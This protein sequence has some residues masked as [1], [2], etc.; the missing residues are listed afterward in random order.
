MNKI[1]KI[2]IKQIENIQKFPIKN[3]KY[4][5]KNYNS[6]NSNINTKKETSYNLSENG[7]NRNNINESINNY[8]IKINKYNEKLTDNTKKSS[9]SIINHKKN[10]SPISITHYT[11]YNK[12]QNYFPS[13]ENIY[14]SYKKCNHNNTNPSNLKSLN[15]NINLV[16]N[17]TLPKIDDVKSPYFAQKAK[18]ILK[19][20][21]GT[22]KKI[23]NLSI[24]SNNINNSTLKNKMINSTRCSNT[25]KISLFNKIKNT[26]YT[27]K[28]WLSI[29]NCSKLYLYDHP[30]ALSKFNI[31]NYHSNRDYNINK[32]SIYK[33]NKIFNNENNSF[34]NS[35]KKDKCHFQSCKFT[36]E[37]IR[38]IL[39]E[40]NEKINQQIK[41]KIKHVKELS[42]IINNNQRVKK[43]SPFKKNRKNIGAINTSYKFL[44]AH[45]RNITQNI[46]SCRKNNKLDRKVR[47]NED[48]KCSESK[49]K[50]KS[51]NKNKII[52]N[53]VKIFLKQKKDRKKNLTNTKLISINEHK[54]KSTSIT[55]KKIIRSYPRQS[56][57]PNYYSSLATPNY[58]SNGNTIKIDKRSHSH[59]LTNYYKVINK[60]GMKKNSISKK[61]LENSNNLKVKTLKQKKDKKEEKNKN[62]NINNNNKVIIQKLNIKT[63]DNQSKH[64]NLSYLDIL[65]F[66]KNDKPN[67]SIVS[68]L[69][70][71]EYYIN[72]MKQ[73]SSYIKDFYNNS[74]TYPKTEINFY[75][76]G[77]VLGKG[78]FG[79]VNLALHL[80]SGRLVAIKSFNKSKILS[81]RA[82]FK[83]KNEIEVLSKLRN[84]FC[85]QIYDFFETE[86]HILIVMEYVCGDLLSFIRK[87]GKISENSSKII[88]K[89]LIKG[90]QYIHNKKIVHRDIKL[91]NILIDLTNTVKIC[92]FGVSRILR[93]GDIMY[94]HC[95]TPAYIS[96][97][98]FE[99]KGYFGYGCD[100]WSAGVTLYYMLAGEQPFKGEKIDEIKENIL[101][102]NFKLIKNI[103]KEANNLLVKMLEPDPKNRISIEQIL[104]H[105][106]LKGIDIKNRKNLNIFSNN[107]KCLLSKYDVN[108]LSSPKEE[109][110]ENFS[111]KNLDTKEDK[112]E[113]GD[114]KSDILAPYNS[115][116]K[117]PDKYL[118]KE[119]KIENDICRFNGK[120]Q[121]SNIQYELSNNQEFDN[122]VIKTQYNS[123]DNLS[124]Q[125][126]DIKNITQS[127]EISNLSSDSINTNNYISFNEEIIED[128]E[129]NIGYNKKYLRECLKKN[130]INY[131]TATYYLM[132]RDENNY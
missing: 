50:S 83:I 78:A 59:T 71:S 90:L 124:K 131:A 5:S 16:N 47:N 15:V 24:N 14:T 27:S 52:Q 64:I 12:Y 127:S 130:E 46:S 111:L 53:N 112:E 69:K 99:N 30:N 123:C 94:E 26:D 41:N 108:Y 110:I 44:N 118:Y 67:Q 113:K 34:Q 86:K 120:V 18:K 88:F 68:T 49:S 42:E 75:E 92:D 38:K 102:G 6:L 62:N 20:N 98:I 93:S 121:L 10:L 66:E 89:Q 60:L 97:E 40:N 21:I 9:Y 106:W 28:D 115:V 132:L 39:I 87:R 79:K 100:V 32:N 55:K 13:S 103:S 2:K 74:N 23:S 45:K 125:R 70:E 29:S 48:K 80:A 56:K 33:K 104:K 43:I 7:S 109:L 116:N 31:S 81:R 77:R 4:S 84:D 82:K 58:K 8:I 114:T 119:I 128:I 11:K 1:K 51:K 37:E 54:S 19:S 126:E 107:E 22:D 105:P 57:M 76:Y 129:K 61:L 101:K 17:N 72:K 36:M 35:L 122:G 95:G 91:D 96:P 25:G 117:E 85:T 65:N 3:L 63:P 73:V